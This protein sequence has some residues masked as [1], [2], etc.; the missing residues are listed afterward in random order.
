MM[1][2]PK[3]NAGMVIG[4]TTNKLKDGTKKV[5]EYYVCGAWKNKGTVACN[6]YAVRT[7]YADPYVLNKIEELMT[8]DKMIQ[9]LVNSINYKQESLIAPI[10]QEYQ[11]YVN[12]LAIL[13]K[14]QSNLLDAYMEE[15]FSKGIYQMKVRSIEEQ[16]S[17]LNGL[18]TPLKEQLGS[19]VSSEMTF[20]QIKNVLQNF[21]KAF[22]QSLTREQRKRLLHLLIHQIT[23]DEERK[24]ESIF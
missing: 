14:K 1:R 4:R 21:Q 3:C 23:I 22:Q 9:Q 8:S 2:C 24:I 16:I 15:T 11:Q 20:E 7:D 19:T 13:E 12:E 17:S 6:S 18:L 5:L 10:Q